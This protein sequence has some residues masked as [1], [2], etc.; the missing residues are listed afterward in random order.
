MCARHS[1]SRRLYTRMDAVE[2]TRMRFEVGD[3]RMSRLGRAEGR[4]VESNEEG[5]WKLYLR[6]RVPEERIQSCEAVR[7]AIWVPEGDGSAWV[8]PTEQNISK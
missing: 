3:H 5:S 8:V 6:A 4:E 1:G 7:D 2:A